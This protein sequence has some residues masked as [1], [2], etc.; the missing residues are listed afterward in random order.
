MRGFKMSIVLD[1][2]EV[3]DDLSKQ[4]FGWVMRVHRGV[5]E[6]EEMQTS[7]HNSLEDSAVG[8]EREIRH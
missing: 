3:I 5:S 6:K 4:C 8:E 7:E 2:M 1:H